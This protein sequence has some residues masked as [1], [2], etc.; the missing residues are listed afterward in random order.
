MIYHLQNPFVIDAAANPRFGTP[1]ITEIK[2]AETSNHGFYRV[3][4]GDKGD[5][6]FDGYDVADGKT[7][8][9][10]PAVQTAYSGLNDEEVVEM[11]REIFDESFAS[12]G[13]ETVEHS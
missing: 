5:L 8:L 1:S 4:G 10:S 2:K 3:I 11:A 6:L 9:Y 12:I 7:F 13:I